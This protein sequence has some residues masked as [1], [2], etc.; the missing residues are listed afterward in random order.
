MLIALLASENKCWAA[1]GADFIIEDKRGQICEFCGKSFRT[2][3]QLG[4]HLNFQHRTVDYTRH[5]IFR[6]LGYRHASKMSPRHKRDLFILS[7]ISR[8]DAEK[9]AGLN[10]KDY[11][12][13]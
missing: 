9:M 13:Q 4:G 2:K 6:A 11:P 10:S 8:T 3:K 1:H 12:K 7:G 5:D